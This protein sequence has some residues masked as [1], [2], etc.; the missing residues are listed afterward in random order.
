MNKKIW[1]LCLQQVCFLSI[2]TLSLIEHVHTENQVCYH[3]MFRYFLSRQNVLQ[4]L[5]SLFLSPKVNVVLRPTHMPPFPN[6]VLDLSE[7][8]RGYYLMRPV[9]LE[10]LVIAM[11]CVTKYTQGARFI[12]ADEKCP[13]SRGN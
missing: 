9:A 7:F 12:C 2:K 11:T 6:Y 3:D 13:C 10:G 5:V 8:P 4:Y 1:Y